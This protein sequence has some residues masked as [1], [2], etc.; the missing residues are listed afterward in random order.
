MAAGT[1]GLAAVGYAAYCCLRAKCHRRELGAVNLALG[2]QSHKSPCAWHTDFDTAGGP[3]ASLVSF[4]VL[5][6]TPTYPISVK[7][8]T[9]TGPK[10]QLLRSIEPRISRG[11]EPSPIARISVVL[12]YPAINMMRLPAGSHAKCERPPITTSCLSNFGGSARAVTDGFFRGEKDGVAVLPEH[13]VRA[14]RTLPPLPL[15]ARAQPAA[16]L[17]LEN[18]SCLLAGNRSYRQCHKSVRV[19]VS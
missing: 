11:N 2:L 12:I 17:A 9:I 16:N 1:L 6:V 18:Q 15:K 8:K 7:S 14:H 5:A 13:C 19:L 10:E 4:C 3:T